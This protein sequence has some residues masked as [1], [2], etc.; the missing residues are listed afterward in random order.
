MKDVFQCD[1][2]LKKHWDFQL[3]QVSSLLLFLIYF[4]KQCFGK[5]NI[6]AMG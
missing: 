1:I 2:L 6:D 4:D 5:K 3:Q